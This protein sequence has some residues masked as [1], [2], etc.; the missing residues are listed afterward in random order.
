MWLTMIS[1]VRDKTETFRD[2]EKLQTTKPTIP[3]PLCMVAEV[4]DKELLSENVICTCK[5][6]QVIL[7][8]VCR[9][10]KQSNFDK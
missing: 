8:Q 4:M 2:C 7:I 9:K 5:K 1:D 3:A 6:R 10:K